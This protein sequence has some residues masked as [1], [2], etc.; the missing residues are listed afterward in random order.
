MGTKRQHALDRLLE[1]VSQ[2]EAHLSKVR[3]RPNS[4]DANH[5][6]S[7]VRGW[8]RHMAR[9]LDKLGKRMRAEWEARINGWWAELGEDHDAE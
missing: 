6:R 1:L 8:L 5:W 3:A 2:V 7:E 9:Q 4:R